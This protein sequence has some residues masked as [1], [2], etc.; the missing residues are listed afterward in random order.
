[1]RAKRAATQQ[2]EEEAP[3]PLKRVTHAVSVAADPVVKALFD[4]EGRIIQISER[5]KEVDDLTQMVL[6]LQ[7][8]V[9]SQSAQLVVQRDTEEHAALTAR[10]KEL[11]QQLQ[12]ANLTIKQ[13]ETDAHHAVIARSTS[14]HMLSLQEN[15]TAALKD[16]LEEVKKDKQ[17]MVDRLLFLE[18]EASQYAATLTKKDEE[19]I[20]LRNAYEGDFQ[21]CVVRPL[22]GFLRA[23]INDIRNGSMTMK[24]T[25]HLVRALQGKHVLTYA[26]F[27]V[28]LDD[29]RRS[30]P[31]GGRDNGLYHLNERRLHETTP[32]LQR[33]PQAPRG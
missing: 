2:P 27:K 31:Q 5:G 25:D 1:M 4:M 28:L 7:A 33:P 23:S 15:V 26:S 18:K 19:I 29:V 9:H 20:A 8:R 22:A 17:L 30:P 14:V 24:Q 3:R 11:E 12:E 13:M 21:R 6:A 16:Q 10:V 32:P